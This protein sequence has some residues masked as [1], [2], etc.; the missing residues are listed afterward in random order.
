M[1]VALGMDG[2]VDAARVPADMLHDVDLAHRGPALAVVRRQH[3]DRRP[4]AAP[5]RQ[6]RADLEEP[7][8]PVGNPLGEDL[9]RRII[10]AAIIGLVLEPL[11]RGGEDQ[12]P[13]QGRVTGLERQHRLDVAPGDD[14]QMDGR[15]RI[16]VAK[17]EDLVVLVLDVGGTLPRRD[18]TEETGRGG[19]QSMRSSRSPRISQKTRTMSGS[20]WPVRDPS[21]RMRSASASSSG[22][23]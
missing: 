21:T 11:D 22:G 19:G 4:D 13:D 5:A 10:L 17:R 23:L 15:L 3:P 8:A 9:A 14:Q 1:V 12:P 2:A 16:D 18:P 20:S 7:I 6:F